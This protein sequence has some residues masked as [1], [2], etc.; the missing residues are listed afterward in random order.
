VD[1]CGC[2]AWDSYY[3]IDGNYGAVFRN[4]YRLGG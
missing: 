1:R 2:D 3:Q 4:R